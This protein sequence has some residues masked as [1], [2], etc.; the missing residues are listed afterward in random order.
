MKRIYLFG[1]AS[2]LVL[3]VLLGGFHWN[4]Y[5]RYRPTTNFFGAGGS[6]FRPAIHPQYSSGARAGAQPY[7]PFLLHRQR[8]SDS[9]PRI[10]L[11]LMPNASAYGYE[12]MRSMTLSSV[13]VRNEH[14]K[15]FHLVDPGKVRTFSLVSSGYGQRREDLGPVEGDR[16]TITAEGT[17][18]TN[19]GETRPVAY[20][21]GWTRTRSTRFGLGIFFAE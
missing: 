12:G 13:T 9:D 16:L 3:L 5:T 18:T 19:T 1:F 6:G 11:N 2:A 8:E 7:I 10:F 21:Q 14:G 4:T 17:V 20:E 15:V